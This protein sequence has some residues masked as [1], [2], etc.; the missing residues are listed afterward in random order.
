ML[1][2]TQALPAEHLRTMTRRMAKL[3]ENWTES[4]TCPHPEGLDTNLGIVP[5]TMVHCYL[6]EQGGSG[7]R[8]V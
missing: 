1:M 6:Q 4:R 2:L 7:I 8:N 5:P 3:T